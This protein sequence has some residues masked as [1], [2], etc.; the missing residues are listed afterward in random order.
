M[1]S[2]RALL[3]LG[4]LLATSGCTHVLY[5]ELQAGWVTGPEFALPA[6][7]RTG[8]I[9][10]VTM[11]LTFNIAEKRAITSAG[12]AGGVG[13]QGAMAFGESVY[14]SGNL[15]IQIVGWTDRV[16]L[17]TGYVFTPD[18]PAR[19]AARA[20]RLQQ[21]ANQRL[22]IGLQGALS[23]QVQ[24]IGSDYFIPLGAAVRGG[25]R[26]HLGNCSL[27]LSGHAQAMYHPTF[28][29]QLGGREEI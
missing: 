22:P 5:P 13:V 14:P 15:L 8:P 10:G 21:I 3:L 6:E 1:M 26:V 24:P 25:P 23:M 28:P 17:H 18:D 16:P 20:K 27:S 11:G 7:Q 2:A 4:T 12:F 9:H 29:F 19:T